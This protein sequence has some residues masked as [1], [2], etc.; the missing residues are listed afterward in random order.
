MDVPRIE[1]GKLLK[2]TDVAEILNISRSLTYRIIQAGQIRS[3]RIGH[4][5][6]VRP[7]DLADYITRNLSP[8]M[9]KEELM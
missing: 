5:K 6:R 3:V 4:A 9:G 2:A 1:S 7:A 8:T